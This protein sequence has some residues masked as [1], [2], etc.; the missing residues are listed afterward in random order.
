[1]SKFDFMAFGYSAGD[2]DIFVAHAEKHTLEETVD[3][4]K[5]EYEH[6]FLKHTNAYGRPV[7][8][9]RLP[10]VEDVQKAHCVFRLGV[11]PE[12]PDG[13]YTLTGEKETGAFPVW[14]IDFE[15]LKATKEDEPK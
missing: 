13:C 6:K 14:V 3:L 2:D 5:R 9:L 11:S 7:Q 4:C 15:R 10:A 12:W 8:A 1:M